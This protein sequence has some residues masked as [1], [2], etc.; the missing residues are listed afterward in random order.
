[1]L[2]ISVRA[3]SGSA[4][5]EGV[6]VLLW[7]NWALMGLTGWHRT[8]DDTVVANAPPA[9]VTWGG[10]TALGFKGAQG[11]QRG[12]RSGFVPGTGLQCLLC[13]PG[14]PAHTE[15]FT[16]TPSGLADTIWSPFF[17]FLDIPGVSLPC[18]FAGLASEVIL[19]GV[20][21]EVNK[22]FQSRT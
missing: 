13:S 8:R 21:H 18:H 10:S 3:S 20:I 22:G 6:D 15:E 9:Q 4:E 2:L 11:H 19:T 17:F 16:K 14:A 7:N 12:C 5:L 1:M